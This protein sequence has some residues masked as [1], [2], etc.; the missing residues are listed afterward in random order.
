MPVPSQLRL[1]FVDD[2]VIAKHQLRFP[3]IRRSVAGPVEFEQPSYL[4]EVVEPVGRPDHDSAVISLFPIVR[5]TR[6]IPIKRLAELITLCNSSRP[7]LM[8]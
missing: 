6:D 3:K 7:D 4:F 2:D 1:F 8:A 5:V